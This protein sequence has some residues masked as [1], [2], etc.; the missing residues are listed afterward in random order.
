MKFFLKNDMSPLL[1]AFA[2]V[3]VVFYSFILGESTFPWD[4]Q[5]PYLTHAIARMRE[6]TFLSPPLWMPWGGF[7]IPGHLSLQDGTWYLPQYLF[8]F[9]GWPYDV[10]GATRLQIAHIFVGSVGI[11]VFLRRFGANR[12]MASAGCLAYIFSP[13]F[14]S[15]AQHVDIVRGTAL[16]PWL[17]IVVDRLCCRVD[18]WRFLL[19]VVVIWQF[20]VGSYPGM[21]VSAGY[22]CAAIVFIHLVNARRE[23]SNVLLVSL[24]MIAAAVTA[25]GLA[26]VKF[27]PSLVDADNFRK[28]P[29]AIVGLDWGLLTSI[30]LDFDLDFMSNDISMRDIF[31]ALPILF[32]SLVGLSQKQRTAL[33]Y[34][35]LVI[36]IIPMVGAKSLQDFI[37]M[38]PLMDVSRFH[39]PDFRPVFHLALFMFAASG[40]DALLHCDNRRSAVAVAF[41]STVVI[42][43]FFL[44]WVVGQPIEAFL[45][46]LISIVFFLVFVFLSPKSSSPT[47][48]GCISILALLMSVA[49]SGYGHEV[50]AERVWKVERSDALEIALFGETIRDL[51]STERGESIEYRP[52]RYVLTALPADITALYDGRYNFS[53]YAQG[54]SAFGYEDLRGSEIFRSLYDAALPIAGKTKQQPMRWML[55]RSSILLLP[56]L[57]Q[58]DIEALSECLVTCR[59]AGVSDEAFV[60]MVAFRS[61]GAVY[62]VSLASPLAV[63]ENEPYYPGWRA[64]ICRE[65]SCLDSITARPVAG[66]LRSWE[67]PAGK[68]RLVTY[69]EPPGWRLAVTI[70]WVSIAVG[71]LVFMVLLF[72]S[73]N[74]RLRQTRVLPRSAGAS[75]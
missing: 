44:G 65:D 60:R 58:F 38:F 26:A 25:S 61:N 48:R 41:A 21:I 62:E 4:F 45:W 29:G 11:Y 59:H 2:T 10:V 56:K 72:L 17:F 22:A 69:F 18:G 7:G 28:S 39:V 49:V 27:V 47:I 31:I 63:V 74:G 53:W 68:Y 54:Y 75:R 1:L 15:N 36:G 12:L 16:M 52:D 30:V 73:R 24:V 37:S 33:P 9:F 35:F 42:A 5:G 46:P 66:V 13:A 70:A 43:L 20:L 34:L 14:F 19:C 51:V 3:F 40:A 64:K 32:L 67:L 6:G 50:R 8:D 71:L 57:S 55:K 23:G